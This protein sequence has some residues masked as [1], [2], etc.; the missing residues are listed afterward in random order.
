MTK[1]ASMPTGQGC[2]LE[3]F[4]VEN[5][6]AIDTWIRRMANGLP[7]LPYCSVDLRYAA[8]KL[9]PVDTNLFPAGFNNLNPEFRSLY[10]Q[11]AQTMMDQIYPRCLRLLLIPENHT[12]NERYLQNVVILH[13]IL[14]QAGIEVCI[15]SVDPELKANREIKLPSG[16]ILTITPIE[17]RG[18]RVYVG[19][20]NPCA[21]LLNHDL[22]EGIPDILKGIHQ[23]IVPHPLL[24]WHQRL[25]SQ[26][27]AHYR[28][29]CESFAKHFSID[30]WQI[31]PYFSHLHNVDIQNAEDRE[32]LAAE[33]EILLKKIQEKYLQYEIQQ[34]P[35]LILKTDSGTYGMGV[36]TVR[37]AEDILTLNRKERNKMSFTK[38]QREIA[39]MLLQE[40][41][42]TIDKSQQATA[43]PV[44]YMMGRSV[45]GGF[46]RVNEQKSDQEN[47]N[48]PGMT[49][50]PM[51]FST[52]CNLPSKVA[53]Y[54]CQQNRLYAYSV[55]ARLA[56]L[57]AMQEAQTVQGVV[58]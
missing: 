22:S 38:G 58:I 56:L 29:I 42:Y 53:A 25:K 52:S 51:P 48:S 46:Y 10:V 47:L 31:D 18:E 17:R 8:Y 7:V 44:M 37:H 6:V 13:G 43:E 41:V 21:I 12:R 28:E 32:R 33:A 49:F 50:Q 19:D 36:I 34:A 5:H 2:G 15:G 57:A 30:A 4:F 1:L 14:E 39:N 40:G 23:S 35:F 9:A 20:F 3:A 55:I 27:F 45:I 11:A 54:D 26:H 16:D 24:G